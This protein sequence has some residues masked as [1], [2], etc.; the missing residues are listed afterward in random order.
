MRECDIGSEHTVVG[1]NNFLRDVCAQYFIDHPM[2]I[3]GPGHIVEIDES[4]FGHR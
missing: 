3:G 4:K 1:W 2:V